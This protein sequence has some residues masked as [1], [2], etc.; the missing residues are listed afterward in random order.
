LG[1]AAWKLQCAVDGQAGSVE[2]LGDQVGRV[3]ALGV[4]GAGLAT[5]CAS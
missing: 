2:E 5:R 4:A 1:I 3:L